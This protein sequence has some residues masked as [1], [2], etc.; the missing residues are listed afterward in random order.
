[1]YFP[2]KRIIF[3]NKRLYL[4]IYSISVS[5]VKLPFVTLINGSPYKEICHTQKQKHYK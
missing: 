1:M 2:N 5:R 4:N 3:S